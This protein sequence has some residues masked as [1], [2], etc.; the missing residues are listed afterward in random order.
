MNADSRRFC[1]LLA[2]CCGLLWT[3]APVLPPIRGPLTVR[4]NQVLDADAG[5]VLM[6]GVVFPGL[7]SSE[8]QPAMSN[9][10]FGVLRLRWNVNTVRL[11]VSVELWV[12]DGQRYL[13]RVASAVALANS[14]EL[15]VGI[16]AR[17]SGGLPTANTVAFWRAVAAH[18]RENPR[19]VFS[20][21]HQPSSRGIPGTETGQRTSS[22]WQFWR[23]GGIAS[24]GERIFGM[25][26]VVDAIRLT[27]ARQLVA[28]PAFHD[29]FGFAGLTAEHEIRD[30]NILYEVQ[31]YFDIAATGAVRDRGFGELASRRPVY[32]GEWGAPIRDGGPACQALP[33]DPQDLSRLLF[34]TLL[35]FENRGISWTVASFRPGNLVED[36]SE[37]QPTLIERP[38][39][40]GQASNPQPGIGTA[41][42]VWTTGDPGGFGY[43]RREAIANAA[44]GPAAPLAPGQL[45]TLYAEQLGPREDTAARFDAEGRLPASIDGTRVLIDDVAAPLLFAGQFQITL[46]VPY[47]LTPGSMASM[48][49]FRGHIPSNQVL[50]PVV[51]AAPE[52]FHSFPL[53][54]A[55]A[56][57]E[58]GSLNSM[59]NPA[60]AGAIVVL[61]ASGCGPITPARPAG[62]AA[63]L[64]HPVFLLPVAA[65]VDSQPAEVL[66]A[67]EV[68][69]FAGLGQINVRLPASLAGNMTRLV[70]VSISAGERRSA[71]PVSIWVR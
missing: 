5:P 48:R 51:E 7:E 53:R 66:F 43:L 47:S 56:V 8:P 32:A 55:I 12:R 6:R 30:S 67:G 35:Y 65:T 39:T 29:A 41:I 63:G 1:F 17:E 61:Y 60:G 19:V 4:G 24:T 69:G 71:N 28:V 50:L 10:T 49:A 54:Y 57:N 18:F 31:P 38:F 16:A 27:G 44:G 33:R 62:R 52:L 22:D 36:Y 68:A 45:I 23:L 58:D 15:A 13:D 2:A 9:A 37:F 34:E 3:H 25:Q 42:L 21:F 70:P 46:Q 64:P 20:I 11:P 59:S 40:C 26:D 14:N